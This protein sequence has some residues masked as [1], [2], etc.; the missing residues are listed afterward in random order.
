[1][2]PVGFH[3]VTALLLHCAF[4][5]YC[6]SDQD[7]L[8]FFL[9]LSEAKTIKSNRQSPKSQI[10]SSTGNGN[11]WKWLVKDAYPSTFVP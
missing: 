8:I 2:N 6:N 10:A 7:N 11:G 5:Q 3:A 9:S 4:D 1:M